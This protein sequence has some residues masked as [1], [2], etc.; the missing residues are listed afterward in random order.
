MTIGTPP[1]ATSGRIHDVARH[2]GVSVGTVSNYFNHPERVSPS[3]TARVEA[4]I[5]ELG[6]VR[7]DAAR[8]LRLG[9]STSLGLIMFDVGNPFF[10]DM[11]RAAEDATAAHGLTMILGNSDQTEAREASYIDLFEKQRVRGVLVSPIGDVT[12][13]LLELRRHGI[14]SVLVDRAS[15]IIDSVSVDDV[16]G[17]YL[18]VKHLLDGGRRRVL[19]VA[20]A[21]A[22]QQSIDRLEGAR[23][24]IAEVPGSSIE[25]VELPVASVLA[26]RELGRAIQQRPSESRPDAVFAVNDVLAIGVLQA[27]IGRGEGLAVPKDVAIVG[28]DDIDFAAS[29]IVPLTSV[30]QPSRLLGERAV[31]LLIERLE[32]PDLA[33]RNVVF[34]PEL[35]V[36]DSSRYSRA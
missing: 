19:Y 21:V 31:E 26:G 29:A 36:R 24:A 27:F 3:A 6:Y 30:R 5:R 15:D 2:A 32:N 20:G 14:E 23:R 9:A 13:R 11:A 10:T 35:I 22:V 25:V 17:G 34:Q 1:R 18:A 28:Y 33:V 8:Q 16:A 4:A 7:N 12:A